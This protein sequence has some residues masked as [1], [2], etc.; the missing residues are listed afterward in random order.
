MVSDDVLT[1]IFVKSYKLKIL[2]E[3][4]TYVHFRYSKTKNDTKWRCN[5]CKGVT[6][7]T[8]EVLVIRRPGKHKCTC[9]L[10][11]PVE[12]AC[13]IKYESLKDMSIEPGFLFAKQYPQSL[14][15]MQI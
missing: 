10:M 14:N 2:F 15:F 1:F 9:K 12:A 3:E 4:M 5:Q 13:L 6:L 8:I 7:K 11:G